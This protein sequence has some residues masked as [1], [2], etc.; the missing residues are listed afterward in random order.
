MC[1]NCCR[2]Q[3]AVT[4]VVDRGRSLGWLSQNRVSRAQKCDHDVTESVRP[5]QKLL[6]QANGSRGRRWSRTK[7]RAVVS[8]SSDVCPEMQSDVTES[9]LQRVRVQLTECGDSRLSLNCQSRTC[10]AAAR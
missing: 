6:T 4:A 9:A 5:V 1:N 2:G 7:P 3:M 10:Q 8:K